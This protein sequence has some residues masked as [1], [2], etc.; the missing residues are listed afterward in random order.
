MASADDN[1]RNA[2]MHGDV[3]EIE[4]LI[5]A[6]ANPNAFEGTDW[7]TPLQWAAANDHIAAIAAL[8]RAG[9]SVNGKDSFGNTPL[10]W[11]ARDNRT[12]AVET[13]VAAGADMHHVDRNGDTALHWASVWGHLD[14]P[15]VLLEAGARTDVRNKRGKRPIDM[16]RAL[17]ARSLW[18]H[19]R[20]VPLRRRFVCAQVGGNTSDKVNDAALSA[21]LASAA[22]WSRRRPLAVACYAVGWE[23]EA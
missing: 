12:V 8:L 9:A 16:V 1:L 14:A 7:S 5:T 22:S 3:V 17:L 4:R 20:I 18:L 11:A 15:R 19:D 6:G 2:A 21:L 10:M 13:L 23:W